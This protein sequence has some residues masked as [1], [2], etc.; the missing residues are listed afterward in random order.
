MKLPEKTLFGPVDDRTFEPH[1][2]EAHRIEPRSIEHPTKEHHT[3]ATAP[4]SRNRKTERFEFKAEEKL[5]GDFREAA[6]APLMD[7]ADFARAAIAAAIERVQGGQPI[8]G[9][10]DWANLATDDFQA[11]Y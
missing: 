4:Q 9:E 11:P 5:M 2:L 10:V 1:R 8:A 7:M 6:S 3:M